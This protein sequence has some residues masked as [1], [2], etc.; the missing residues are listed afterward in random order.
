M[1]YKATFLL[2]LTLMFTQ[3]TQALT[4]NEFI[5]YCS[6]PLKDQSYCLGYVRGAADAMQFWEFIAR[7]SARVCIPI[8]VE[9]HQLRDVGLKFLR[10]HP[11]DRHQPAMATL[12]LAFVETWPCEIDLGESK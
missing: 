6:V 4:G 9:A 1:K 8:K 3:P 11:G 10:E 7:D 5:R 2:P 12:A